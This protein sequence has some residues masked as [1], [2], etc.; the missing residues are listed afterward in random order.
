MEKI[1]LSAYAEIKKIRRNKIGVADK[2]NAFLSSN[3]ATL[4]KESAYVISAADFLGS[5]A[6]DFHYYTALKMLNANYSEKL[7]WTFNLSKNG[8]ADKV[9]IVV[10]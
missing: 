7:D 5:E 4:K 6:Q 3:I 8:R 1:T 10:K 2:L 9:T